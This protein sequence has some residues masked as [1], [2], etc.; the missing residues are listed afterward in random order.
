MMQK[1]IDAVGKK[2]LAKLVGL[3]AIPVIATLNS[4]YSLGL[5]DTDI[6]RLIELVIAYIVGQSIADVASKGATSATLQAA[7]RNAAFPTTIRVDSSARTAATPS[8]HVDP[9]SDV[10]GVP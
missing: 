4:R 5:T 2:F 3:V 8:D 1:L 10:P 9:P 6:Q 7:A